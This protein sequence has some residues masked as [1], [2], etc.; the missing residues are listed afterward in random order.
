MKK[1]GQTLSL[2]LSILL[3]AGFAQA[4]LQDEMEAL[5]DT[6]RSYVDTG[7]ICEEVAR[8]DVQKEFPKPQYTVINGIAYSG[9][10]GTIGELDVVIFDNNTQ[11]VIKIAEVK[12]W[13]DLK[14]GLKKARDQRQRFL[15]WNKSGK[16]LKFKSTSDGRVFPQDQF[17]YVTEFVSIAQKGATRSG[18]DAELNYTL[19]EL[20]Q[21]RQMMMQ[22]QSRG[23]CATAGK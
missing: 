14:G 22:C 18:F 23:E 15:S 16:K 12:C 20:M 2:T 4:S 3:F 6:P 1:F 7:A 11:K 13:K 5:R 8:L 9:E 17:D 19:P 10:N 21:L